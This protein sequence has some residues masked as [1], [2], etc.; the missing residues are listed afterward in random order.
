[1]DLFTPTTINSDEG[2]TFYYISLLISLFLISIESNSLS[3]IHKRIGGVING[4]GLVSPIFMGHGLG[5]SYILSFLS[6][7]SEFKS[8]MT[9]LL[10]PAPLPIDLNAI[11]AFSYTLLTRSSMREKFSFWFRYLK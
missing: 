2:I 7:K 9:I 11:L 6:Q 3:A 1:L 4:L 10:A 8:D 5:C